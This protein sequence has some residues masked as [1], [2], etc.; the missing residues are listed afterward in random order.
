MNPGTQG[1]TAPIALVKPVSR[2]LFWA[3]HTAL[4]F[5]KSTSVTVRTSALNWSMPLK[6]N[7][8]AQAEPSVTLLL[9]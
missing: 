8:W 5:S 1:R 9:I 4:K 3:P 6:M 2:E 7:H